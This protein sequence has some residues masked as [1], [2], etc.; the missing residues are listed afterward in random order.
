[1]SKIIYRHILPAHPTQ[2]YDVYRYTFDREIT[3]ET[4][5]KCHVWMLVEGESVMLETSEGM[6]QRFNYAETFV[7]PAEARSYRICNEGNKKAMM[8]KAFVK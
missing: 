3:V 8:I 1:M 4:D 2:F 7:V 5:D 6:Q